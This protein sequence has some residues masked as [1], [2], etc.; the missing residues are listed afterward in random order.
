MATVVRSLA[1]TVTL[2]EYWIVIEWYPCGKKANG[3]GGL[4]RFIVAVGLVFRDQDIM[5]TAVQAMAHPAES[6]SMSFWRV[7]EISWP[8]FNNP[9]CWWTIKTK[10]PT[11]FF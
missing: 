11:S 6:V 7:I 8:M 9:I 4:D 5:A 1:P 3:R 2:A 10:T